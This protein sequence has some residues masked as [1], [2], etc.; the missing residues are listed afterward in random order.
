MVIIFFLEPCF[1]M[2]FSC[3]LQA[4]ESALL[5]HMRMHFIAIDLAVF[6]IKGL[7]T[8][9]KRHERAESARCRGISNVRLCLVRVRTARLF[10]GLAVFDPDII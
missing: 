1:S 3:E 8:K 6:P 4:V 7:L 9:N 10:D 2:P 5:N